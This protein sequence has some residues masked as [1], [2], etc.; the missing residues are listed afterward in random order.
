M[1]PTTTKLTVEKR[2]MVAFRCNSRVGVALV[3]VHRGFWEKRGADGPAMVRGDEGKARRSVGSFSFKSSPGDMAIS[4]VKETERSPA[5][6]LTVT[7][8]PKE[9]TGWD[10]AIGEVETG[11]DWAFVE[12]V[13]AGLLLRN[14]GARESSV[15]S[16]V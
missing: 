12:R 11:P 5:S 3:W 16:T 7:E 8:P 14:R 15:N 10:D 4:G 2:G 13:R 6:S 9:P 1:I